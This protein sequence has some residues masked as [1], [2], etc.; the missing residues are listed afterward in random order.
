M[1]K[2]AISLEGVN[3]NIYS[4][5]LNETQELLESRNYK[6]KLVGNFG[7]TVHQP[8]NPT[9]DYHI[10]LSQDNNEILSINRNGSAHDGYHGVRI[11]NKAYKALKA[12]YPDWVWPD[13]QIIESMDYALFISKDHLMGFRP[14]QVVAHTTETL[15]NIPAFQG[16][17]HRFADE[18]FLAGGNVGWVA[19]T[20]AIVEDIDGR[21]FIIRKDAF[22]FLDND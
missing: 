16:I 13:N 15:K 3:F 12:Q 2:N 9:G 1:I 6:R 7:V 18:P 22:R 14:V 5:D 17:F 10:H 21:I 4:H 19:R 11:P 20:V 8:H